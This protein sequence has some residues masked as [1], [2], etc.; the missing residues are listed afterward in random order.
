LLSP[1]V[2]NATVHFTTNYP[3]ADGA[4]DNKPFVRHPLVPVTLALHKGVRALNPRAGLDWNW[5]TNV[6]ACF[7]AL[8]T[9][10]GCPGE[11]DRPMH[12]R[13][14]NAAPVCFGFASGLHQ[15][16]NWR[17]IPLS[18]TSLSKLSQRP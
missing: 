9:I 15:G 4:G 12:A 2:R 14:G 1:E 18:L 10:Q 3:I 13:P 11:G 5:I 7:A 17:N 16:A 6:A 8:R